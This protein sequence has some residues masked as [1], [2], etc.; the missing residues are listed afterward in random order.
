MFQSATVRSIICR[1]DSASPEP[2]VVS[3]GTNQLKHRFGSSRAAAPAKGGKNQTDPQVQSNLRRLHNPP[4]SG[5]IRGGPPQAGELPELSSEDSATFGGCRGLFSNPATSSRSPSPRIGGSFP[6][7]SPSGER[8]RQVACC[9][10]N[11]ATVLPKPA[12]LSILQRITQI[13]LKGCCTAQIFVVMHKSVSR[14]ATAIRRFRP[15]LRGP[16]AQRDG[17]APG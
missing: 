1:M 15:H 16:S 3:A 6:F 14:C 4:P 10:N 2:R 7:S 17:S 5:C 11:R 9:F 13:R 12:I 8:V